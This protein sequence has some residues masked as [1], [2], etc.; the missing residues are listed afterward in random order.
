MLSGTLGG[1]DSI[2]DVSPFL[3]G[4]VLGVAV[5]A[6]VGPMSL[7]CMRR[8]LAGGFPAGF[9][10]GLG[11][12]TADAI[13][14]AIAAFGLVAVTS[15]LVGYAVWL[16]LVGA[17]VLLYLG[18]TTLRARPATTTADAGASGL[19]GTYASTLGLT[20]ANPSTILSFAALFAGLGLGENEGGPSAASA[21]VLGVFLGSAL[22]WLVLTGGIGLVRDRLSARGMYLVNVAAGLALVGFGLLALMST[23]APL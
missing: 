8:A 3:R 18:L 23:P 19:V 10:S 4:L 14:G 11:V 1:K 5:A 2:M 21:M 20:L 13:Y 22:W 12:A 17:A 16:R 6:P 15:V 9:L 7:L